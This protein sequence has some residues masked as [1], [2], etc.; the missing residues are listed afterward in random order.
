MAKE[1]AKTYAKT[2]MRRRPASKLKRG[3]MALRQP[4]ARGQGPATAFREKTAVR[5]RRAGRQGCDDRI[6]CASIQA[7]RAHGSRKRLVSTGGTTKVS[8]ACWTL[9]QQTV[10]LLNHRLSAMTSNRVQCAA[11]RAVLQSRKAA[12]WRDSETDVTAKAGRHSAT[13]RRSFPTNK[14]G[15]S[16]LSNYVR[17][18]RRWRM[19]GSSSL[20]LPGRM[21]LQKNGAC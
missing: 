11:L 9:A 3:P 7:N 10:C 8:Q 13:C 4:L 6:R 5:P 14:L 17:R 19:Q 1:F 15:G 2:G 16:R 18:Q 20:P 21:L 12:A